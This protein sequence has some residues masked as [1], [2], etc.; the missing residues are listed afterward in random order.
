MLAL[1]LGWL[2]HHCLLAVGPV[3]Q[4]IID[5]SLLL[6]WGPAHRPQSVGKLIQPGTHGFVMLMSGYK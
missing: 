5:A 2:Q 3:K 4:Q 6:V 1:H